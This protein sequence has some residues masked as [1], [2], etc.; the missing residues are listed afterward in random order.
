MGIFITAHGNFGTAKCLET[1][2]LMTKERKGKF[3]S[4]AYLMLLK[5]LQTLQWFVRNVVRLPQNSVAV[6]RSHGAHSYAQL[7][8][9]D[10]TAG[11]TLHAILSD[12]IR[13]SLPIFRLLPLKSYNTLHSNVSLTTH[14]DLT[15]HWQRVKNPMP[16]YWNRTQQQVPPDCSEV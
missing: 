8:W 9:W 14:M 4:K 12:S 1:R 3:A 15:E 11:P 16:P 5:F 7:C 2:R 6:K 13:C 10:K